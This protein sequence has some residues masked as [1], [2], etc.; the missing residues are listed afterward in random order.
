MERTLWA[1][2]KDKHALCLTYLCTDTGCTDD[3]EEGVSFWSHCHLDTWEQ[4]REFL[5][6]FLCWTDCVHKNLQHNTETKE[7]KN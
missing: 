3:G 4:V 2:V 6:V 5:L 1:A 7:V